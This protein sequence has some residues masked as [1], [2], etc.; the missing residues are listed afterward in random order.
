[1]SNDMISDAGDAKPAMAVSPPTNSEEEIVV[2]GG[3]GKPGL[4]RTSHSGVRSFV[5]R[6]RDI[7]NDAG[8]VQLPSRN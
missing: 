8:F 7:A 1:M 4:S 3:N 5:S 2:N 6:K